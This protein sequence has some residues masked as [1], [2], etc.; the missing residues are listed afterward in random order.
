MVTVVVDEAERD[1]CSVGVVCVGRGF[2]EVKKTNPLLLANCRPLVQLFSYRC[3]QM[4]SV[5]FRPFASEK[6]TPPKMEV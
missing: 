4:W 1:G 2:V 5:D 3:L 6:Q